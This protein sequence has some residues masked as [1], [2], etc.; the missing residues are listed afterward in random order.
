MLLLLVRHFNRGFQN[1]NEIVY[2]IPTIFAYQHLASINDLLKYAG[3]YNHD[4][5]QTILLLNI[6][7][8]FS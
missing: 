6:K 8:K 2:I 4:N 5:Y 7:K 1:I 3:L